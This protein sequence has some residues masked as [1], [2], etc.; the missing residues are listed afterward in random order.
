MGRR[1]LM[2]DTWKSKKLWFAVG[3]I[4]AAFVYSI[5]GASILPGLTHTYD[6]FVGVLEFAAGAYLTGN[7]ANKL[8]I[9]KANP[10]TDKTEKKAPASAKAGGP[11]VP[12]EES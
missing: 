12:D 2:H 4:G 3:V 8:V 5:L 11:K 1:G 9:A 10:G 7:V 6:G